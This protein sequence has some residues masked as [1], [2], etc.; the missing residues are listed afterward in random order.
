VARGISKINI[1]SE[2]RQAYRTTLEEQLKAHPEQFAVVKLMGP[3]L[4][5][6]QAVVEEKLDGF[7]AAGKRV[8]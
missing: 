5:A 4:D 8:R 6:V 2:L 7:G 1:N 3:V